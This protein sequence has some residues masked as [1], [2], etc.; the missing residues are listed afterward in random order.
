MR[1][2]SFTRITLMFGLLL[3]LAAPVWAAAP[4]GW[5]GEWPGTDFTKHSVPFEEIISGGPPKDGIP[6][7]DDPSFMPVGEIHTLSDR[8]PVIRVAIGE[9]VRAYPLSILMWHEI[10]NDT[11]GGIPVAVTYCPLCNAS[12]VFDRRVAGQTLSFGTTG[13]LRNSDLVM[14]DRQSESWWQQF[15]GEAIVG[16][17]TG[18]RLERLPARV[19][20]FGRFRKL[21]PAGVVMVPPGTHARPYG[22]NPYEGY[23]SSSWP[24]LFKG[25]YPDAVPPLSYV[26][27]V[28]GEAWSLELL[29]R[30]GRVESGDL[31]IV[32]DAGMAS[33]LDT[34][35]VATGRDVGYVTVTRDG[36]EIPHDV[37]FAF[38]FRAFHPDGQLHVPD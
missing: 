8:E 20:P 3:A 21:A 22:E 18:T 28:G 34:G 16:A 29:R 5:R 10:V 13:K 9:D 1:S 14:Y 30:A 32:W 37:S 17:M 4:D 35:T 11:V 33:A 26:V 25:V 23:D 2:F 7:I 19:E 36:R 31:V 38:V 15:S 6:A 24:F 12:I 27:I